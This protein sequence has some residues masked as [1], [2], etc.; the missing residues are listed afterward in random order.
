M[1]PATTFIH[2]LLSG[3]HRIVSAYLLVNMFHLSECSVACSNIHIH[4]NRLSY[5]NTMFDG[6]C[7][8]SISTYDCTAAVFMCL[9]HTCC[10]SGT[11]TTGCAWMCAYNVGMLA[12]VHDVCVVTVSTSAVVH[13]IWKSKCVSTI[14]ATVHTTLLAQLHHIHYMFGHIQRVYERLNN[15]HTHTK[16]Y[17]H[18]R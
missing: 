15:K 14:S 4:Y 1:H 10:T 5:V 3:L 2:V 12:N 9:V 8:I 13:T 17:V 11:G 18:T 7:T 6:Y 16:I